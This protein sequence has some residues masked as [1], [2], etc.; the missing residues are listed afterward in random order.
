MLENARRLCEA[1]Y[2]VLFLYNRDEFRVAAHHGVPLSWLEVYGR[3]PMN[4][5]PRTGLG[6]MRD[7]LQAIHIADLTADDAYAERDPV[8]MATV[9]L[10]GGRTFLAVPLLKG[11]ELIGAFV[12][13]RKRVQPFDRKQIGL[14]TSFAGQA[15]IAIE[16]TRLFEE[17]QER[18]RELGQALEYQTAISDVLGVIGRSKFDLQP[19][20][21]AIV[22]TACRL[23]DANDA[24][25]ALRHGDFLEFAAG[26]GSAWVNNEWINDEPVAAP[27]RP[28]TCL[29]L[30]TKLT[31]SECD[32]GTDPTGRLNTETRL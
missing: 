6:R 24:T 2:G 5:G 27:C 29:G 14:A 9:Q 13:Y 18:T 22:S 4:P 15:V 23:C 7:T 1:E 12:L 19:V 26:H 3:A 31:K 21:T 11:S 32:G 25:I 8:R 17:V 28:S 30:S 20:L 10:L 16:N